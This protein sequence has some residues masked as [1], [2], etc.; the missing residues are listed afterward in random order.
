MIARLTLILAALALA[1]AAPTPAP[2]SV[3]YAG[4]LV[5]PM[6]G[7][8]K[9]ALLTDGIA[10]AGE[11]GGSTKLRNFIRDGLR[12]PDVFISVDPTLVASLGR[13]VARATTFANTTLGVA[14]SDKSTFAAQLAH[15]DGAR[16]R[17]ILS[18]PGFKLGR[19]DPQLDPKG[20]Y[21]IEALRDIGAAALT[22]TDENPAQVFPEEDLLVRIDTGEIDAGI[23]YETEATA[24]GLHFLA[25]PGKAAMSDRIRYTLAVM[26]NAPRPAQAAAFERF[27]LAG[28]GRT[29]LTKAGLHYRSP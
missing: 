27:I 15:M 7:A 13:Q 25:F 14:W 18:L 8:I 6:E 28:K 21:S 20:R 23:F 1:G 29:I 3:L 5:T 17:Y 24:R 11:P 9:S 22:G 26:Q 2:V 4:S 10:F 19:T 12:T 16:I